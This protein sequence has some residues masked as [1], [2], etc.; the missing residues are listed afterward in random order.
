LRYTP[1]LTQKPIQREPVMR[2]FFFLSPI[3]LLLLGFTAGHAVDD[4]L[5]GLLLQFKTSEEAAKL[6]IFH[7]VTGP[8]FFIPNVKTLRDLSLEDRVS[9]I[10]LIGKNT[11][12]Y[13]ASKEFIEKYNQYRE[14]KKP[15]A[16]ETPKYST[17]LKDEQ[18][19]NL[20]K[21]IAEIEKNK[22]QVTKDQQVIFDD[23][24]KGLN[25][26]LKEMDNPKNT[27]YTPEMDSYIK[28][29][30][31][32]Q[33]N[34]HTKSVAAW[35]NMYPKNNPNPM[36]KNWINTFLE[37]SAG[38]NFEAKTT[39]IKNGIIKFIDQEYE[40]KDSQWKLY[41]RAGKETVTAARS[42]AQDWLDE[43]K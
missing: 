39:E 21:S 9:I 25:Q 36:I 26:Q 15:K 12:E 6:D 41:F 22:A 40:R 17:Q 38:I 7:A 35:E 18:R 37:K 10:Q 11:K 30:H 20:K 27:M 2:K 28:Q 43:L 5:N 19:E 31:E 8:S 24:I 42:F 1:L 13:L 23:I 4:K 14:D 3:L 33:M 16:P 34:E 29:S 32:M